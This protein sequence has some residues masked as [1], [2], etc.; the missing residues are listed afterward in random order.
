MCVRT[1]NIRI[2]ML[3][4]WRLKVNLD[5]IQH[6]LLETQANIIGM[7]VLSEGNMKRKRI[8]KRTFNMLCKLDNLI[9]KETK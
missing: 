1:W 7:S 8:L 4:I 6:L 5:N 9:K 3:N 2:G